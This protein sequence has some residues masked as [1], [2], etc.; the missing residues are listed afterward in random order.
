MHSR[1][2]LR[3]E[4]VLARRRD[5]TSH[6]SWGPRVPG[7]AWRTAARG[8][9]AAMPNPRVRL[10]SLA[11]RQTIPPAA[12]LGIRAEVGTHGR[13]PCGETVGTPDA[14]GDSAPKKNPKLKTSGRKSIPGAK[15]SVETFET[16]TFEFQF[17][18]FL[19]LGQFAPSCQ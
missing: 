8:V 2:D 19:L 4:L 3:G 9:H 12:F 15:K 7:L 6:P 16:N 1:C 13:P 11:Q 17:I 14:I 10:L 5:K 18:F